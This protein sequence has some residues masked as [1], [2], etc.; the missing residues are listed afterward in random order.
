MKLAI[1]DFD[2]TYINIQVL[3][4]IFRLWKEKGLN[5]TKLNKVYRMIRRRYI[6][7]KLRL[8]G[9]NKHTFRANA[10]ALTADLFRT[11]NRDELNV[12]LQD[13][14]VHLQKFINTDIRNQLETDKKNGYYTILLSGNFNIILEPFLNEGFDEV[15]GTNVVENNEI[16]KSQD[17]KIIIHNIKQEVIKNKFKKANFKESKAYADSYYDLPILELVGEPVVVNPD[18]E[19]IKI[20][21]SRGYI[22][23]EKK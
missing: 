2:G 21:N 23:F 15:I 17:V 4:E 5:E 13:L 3:P 10:M 16:I 11:V 14:Y 22:F 20:A 1:Y 19:L 7:H 12:F 8:F 9:W 18:K 6:F